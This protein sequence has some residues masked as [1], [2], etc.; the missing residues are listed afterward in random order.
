MCGLCCQLWLN[1]TRNINDI[2]SCVLPVM[3]LLLCGS[4]PDPNTLRWSALLSRDD[5]FSHTLCVCWERSAVGA[6]ELSSAVKSG[7][8][9]VI[10]G[11]R[12]SRNVLSFRAEAH[13]HWDELGLC[14]IMRVLLWVKQAKADLWCLS[15]CMSATGCFQCVQ[16]RGVGVPAAPLSAPSV[17][18][19]QSHVLSDHRLLM[20]MGGA[21][22]ALMHTYVYD[23]AVLTVAS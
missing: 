5:T 23:S 6:C 16:A 12:C 4:S 17:N 20:R 18:Y 9:N 8:W 19:I 15:S 1:Q 21:F 11:G 10:L 3:R 14:N 22:T 2:T 7:A 13:P